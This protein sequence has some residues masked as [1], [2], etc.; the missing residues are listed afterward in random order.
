MRYPEHAF[1][2]P[3]HDTY[4]ALVRVGSVLGENVC[5]L[6]ERRYHFRL[7]DGELLAITPES[8]G[9]LR[10]ERVD[11]GREGRSLWTHAEDLDRLTDLVLELTDEGV[12]ASA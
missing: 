11:R 7:R 5:W 1:L 3:A 12:R 10:L 8:G 4:G 9:R 2:P 6:Y